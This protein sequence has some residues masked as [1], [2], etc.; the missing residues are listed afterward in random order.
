MILPRS[1]AELN[2]TGKDRVLEVGWTAQG[3]GL[4]PDLAE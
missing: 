4:N 2:K 1:K 3:F